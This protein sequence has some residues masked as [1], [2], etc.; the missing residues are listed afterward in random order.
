[1]KS[2]SLDAFQQCRNDWEYINKSKHSR[3]TINKKLGIYLFIICLIIIIF[4]TYMYIYK[5]LIFNTV[6]L[7]E[8]ISTCVTLLTVKRNK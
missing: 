5:P 3:M 7:S 2:S 4:N 8:I 1:M 6:F